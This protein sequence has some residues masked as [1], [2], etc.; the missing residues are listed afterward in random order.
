MQS[1]TD[2]KNFILDIE[3]KFPV[4]KWKINNIHIWPI[5]RLNLYFFLIRKIELGKTDE[6]LA[7]KSIPQKKNNLSVKH[8][9]KQTRNN[10]KSIVKYHLWLRNLS[11]KKFLFYCNTN[12]NVVVDNKNITKLL[13]PLIQKYSINKQSSFMEVGAKNNYPN[14]NQDINI[15]FNSALDLFLIKRN[16]QKKL[17]IVKS[18]G[19]IDC[20]QYDNFLGLLSNN[21]LTKGFE[22]ATDNL[23]SLKNNFDFFYPLFYSILKNISPS[24]LFQVCYY[25]SLNSFLLI[26]IARKLNIKVIEMQHGPQTDVHLAYGNWSK[27]PEAGYNCMPNVFWNWDIH[28]KNTIQSWSKNDSE[29]KSFVGGNPWLEYWQHKSTNIES[30]NFILYSLQPSPLKLENLFPDTLL[31]IIKTNKE[32]WYLRLHPLQLNEKDNLIEFLKAKEVFDLVNIDDATNRTLPELLISCKIHITNFSGSAIEAAMFNK[33]SIII[34]PIGEIGF[35]ELIQ[36]NHARYL[37]PVDENFENDFFD[38]LN[39]IPTISYKFEIE[40]NEISKFFN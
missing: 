1:R 15:N 11:K 8:K 34:H 40:V 20:P 4:D 16:Y 17:G 31:R 30:K 29:I 10:L 22:K 9:L 24:Y 25:G 7:L 27:I 21:Y 35:K 33:F 36:L 13:Y 6:E 12:A 3:S 28:S 18:L 26:S 19:K 38:L 2:I 5:V 39:N 37:N 32:K 23:Q 14:L